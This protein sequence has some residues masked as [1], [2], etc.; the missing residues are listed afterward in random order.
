MMIPQMVRGF[1]S[2]IRED[3]F[4]TDK[5]S[6]RYLKNLPLCENLNF[7]TDV[8]KIE[9]DLDITYQNPKLAFLMLLKHEDCKGRLKI[10]LDPKIKLKDLWLDPNVWFDLDGMNI[11]NLKSLKITSN[12]FFDLGRFKDLEFVYLNLTD[13]FQVYRFITYRLKKNLSTR[14]KQG[15]FYMDYSQKIQKCYIKWRGKPFRIEDFLDD[16]D[17]ILL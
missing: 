3:G 17:K 15:E 7:C 11:E 9:K 4:V 1:K 14:I 6:K 13:N 5:N 2:M 8:F 12:V 10:S 16:F